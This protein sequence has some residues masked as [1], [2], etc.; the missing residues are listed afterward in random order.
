MPNARNI[1]APVS[2][3][4]AGRSGTS[5]I[6]GIFNHHPDFEICGETAGLILPAFKAAENVQNYAPRIKGMDKP[7]RAGAG[8]R[9]MF[10]GMFPG[11]AEQWFQKPLGAINSK[12]YQRKPAA[13][14]AWYWSAML[15]SFPEGR[16]I[17][18]LRHPFDVVLSR[19]K[20]FE[21]SDGEA[22]GT[23]AEMANVINAE[24][25]PIRVA[26]RYR[27]LVAEP[28]AELRRV[29]GE[30]GVRWDPACLAAMGTAYVTERKAD[31]RRPVADVQ[32][33]VAKGFSSR[34]RWD[35]V[36]AGALAPA[37]RAALDAMWARFGE[38]I[39]WP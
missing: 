11:E 16:F 10:L 37:A 13:Y 2:L 6:Q 26:I 36:D 23:L 34:E 24:Q 22:F 32:E 27:E 5:L 9:G 8:V 39:D 14:L 28:E 12:A 18:V 19:R 30:I 4:S 35:E 15:S 20:W 3:I 7:T 1:A 31:F 17:T 38:E 21:E 33:K 29:F 25:S